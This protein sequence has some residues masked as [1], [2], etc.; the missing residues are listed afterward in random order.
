MYSSLLSFLALFLAIT[1]ASPLPTEP[2]RRQAI[3]CSRGVHIIH[4]RGSTQTYEASSVNPVVNRILAGVPGSTAEQVQFPATIIA[5]DS[6]YSTSVR[7]GIVD[8]IDKIERYVDAC[9]DSSRIVLLG[10]SQGGNVV[11]SALA[12]GLVK[13]LP[14]NPK[15][16]G[17]STLDVTFDAPRR[18]IADILTAS[19][20]RGL[21]RRPNAYE[22]EGLYVRLR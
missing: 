17:K 2:E 5:D 16:R 14:L 21:L 10:Y 9:G 4:A 7:A 11:T 3:T 19:P 8:T 15:Y 22:E 13:W 6:F 12:G 18:Q 1:T 20:C